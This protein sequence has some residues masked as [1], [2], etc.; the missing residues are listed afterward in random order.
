MIRAVIALLFASTA[1]GQ[2]MSSNARRIMSVPVCSASATPSTNDVLTYDGTCWNVG[3]VV[4]AGTGD[5]STNTTTT[6]TGELVIY[7][8]TGGKL[9]ARS[10]FILAGPATTAKTYTFPNS[11]A[12]MLYASGALGTPASGTLTNATGL[13]FSGLAGGTNTG[14]AMVVGA[15]ASLRTAAGIFGV[16]ASTTLPVACTIGDAY[17][18]T[19]ATSGARWYLCEATDTWVAQ[20]GAGGSPSFDQVTGGTN[21]AALVVGT[22]GSLTVSG[23]G[24]INA[25]SLGG[26][27]A[28]S[29]ALLASPVFTTLVTLPSAAAP[30]VDA[31]GEIAQDDNL[32]AASRGSLVTF[33]GTAATA[34]V[35]VLVSDTPSNGQVLKWNTGGTITWE[36]D[37]TGGTPSF[38]AITGA[39]N[40]TAAMVVGSGGSLRTAAGIFGVPASTSLPGTCTVG[41]AYMDTDATSGA[42]W[43]L[44]EST[45]TWAAQGGGGAMVYPEAGIPISTGSAWSTSITNSS[46]VGQTLRV[47]GASTYAFGALDLADTDAVT[48]VLPAANVDTAIARLASPSFTTP[49]LGAA[50]ATSIASGA[51][52][53]DTGVFRL[54]NNESICWEISTPGTDL[55]MKVNASDEFEFTGTGG[56]VM[57]L[58]EIASPAAPGTAEQHKLYFDTDG[59][60]KHIE[61]GGSEITFTTT[62][63]NLSAF[64]ATTS[65]ELA[66]VLS[67][68]TG[69]G[70]AVF[71]T[72]P[73]F[74][75]DIRA[76]TAGGATLG[77][78]AL[79]FS[80]AYIGGAATNNFQITGTA[81]AARVMT[82]PDV[83]SATFVVAGTSTTTTQ[84]LF[85]TATAGAPAYRAVA[86][87][88]LPAA[89]NASGFGASFDGGGSAIA[90]N[91]T[92]YMTISHACTIAA[93]NIMVDTGTLTFKVWR[94]A[95]GTAVPTSGNS[96]NT[97]GIAIST[98]TALRTTT[99]SDYTDTTLDINDIL[100]I[101]LTAVS[102]ATKANIFVECNR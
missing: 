46:T 48:G 29:Y 99:T 30:T 55:C 35:G 13:P 34:L 39:T 23:S 81:T 98:G 37:S 58:T 51:D 82:L 41:D 44:C 59:L 75:T 68:E 89:T 72:S 43:Y 63:N 8:N 54:S 3:P 57:T 12:T 9:G 27:A 18:D 67:N 88:D 45:N 87:T 40:T 38:D 71:G 66:G 84:A 64:A 4:G 28:A 26:T 56:S 10:L 100:A 69:T 6:A 22:G 19:N 92:A 11:D 70:V 93:S 86:T 78:G 14:A 96:I 90:A 65:A 80:S 47:T 60:L 94:V 79:P 101:T 25:T 32:W 7:G 74:T 21:A 76:A 20:G 5:F 62:L 49:T 77:T 83:T 2:F 17:M 16:P 91:S 1:W 73:S 53:A 15:G 61:N 33:D 85:A 50:V 102:G 31:V 42:R 97:S 52:P 36:A 24:T 95:T